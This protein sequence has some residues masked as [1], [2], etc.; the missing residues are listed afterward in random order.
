MRML[1]FWNTIVVLC[2]RGRTLFCSLITSHARLYGWLSV[3]V[4]HLLLL[5][6]VQS[7]VLF[8][9]FKSCLLLTHKSAGMLMI[10]FYNEVWYRDDTEMCVCLVFQCQQK[11]TGDPEQLMAL[12]LEC[13]YSCERDDQ[14]ALSY[15][16]LECLPQRGYGLACIATHS[17]HSDVMGCHLRQNWY[18]AFK[19]LVAFKWE[20]RVFLNGFTFHHLCNS[21]VK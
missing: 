21:S 18:Y 6:G 19:A 3:S 8:Q 10:W 14:L 11:I 7:C 17:Q 2:F 12:A 5:T 4:Y 20:I 1:V 9:R 13:I 15:D 16:I